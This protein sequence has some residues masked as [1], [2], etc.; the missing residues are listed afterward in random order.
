MEILLGLIG[1]V[2]GVI[3]AAWYFRGRGS[4]PLTPSEQ[5]EREL[6]A[7]LEEIRELRTEIDIL[8]TNPAIGEAVKAALSH[9]R[10]QPDFPQSAY[11]VAVSP[12]KLP[13][14]AYNVLVRPNPLPGREER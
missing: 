9:A 11:N 1:V 5:R 10:D 6:R 14:S 7:V 8:K 2:V 3:G 4:A 13:A 12:G